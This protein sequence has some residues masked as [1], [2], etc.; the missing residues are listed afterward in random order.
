M[1]NY[2]DAFNDM[3]EEYR[4][5]VEA[6]MLNADDMPEA[7]KAIADGKPR[8]IKIKDGWEHVVVSGREKYTNWSVLVCSLWDSS[9]VDST[10]FMVMEDETP[11]LPYG[12]TPAPEKPE[13]NPI[14][15]EADI[16]AI[17]N[18]GDGLYLIAKDKGYVCKREHFAGYANN[19]MMVFV[20]HR[21][22]SV[23]L[24]FSDVIEYG[25]AMI[26]LGSWWS[27]MANK[28]ENGAGGIRQPEQIGS[29]G[30]EYFAM[31]AD[32][33]LFVADM[34]EEGRAY[35]WEHT[36]GLTNNSRAFHID[37]INALKSSFQK[38]EALKDL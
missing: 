37:F 36:N 12:E 26:G 29:K 35:F 17:L 27:L 20:D 24:H 3:P 38:A 18:D 13:G 31:I 7:D 5:Y 14:P 28:I 10:A 1:I 6:N 15:T 21:G 19:E 32:L 33:G 34:T 22:D 30:V 25:E 8:W 9:N 2:G 4:E 23:N 16:E 11:V